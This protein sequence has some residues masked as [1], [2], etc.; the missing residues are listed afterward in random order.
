METT[1]KEIDYL[2]TVRNDFYNRGFI[3]QAQA[4]QNDINK[5]IEKCKTPK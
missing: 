2:T 4:V 1:I 3:K 5:L